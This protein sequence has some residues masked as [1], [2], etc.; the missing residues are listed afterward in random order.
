MLRH[1]S[2]RAM[3]LLL[4]MLV[5]GSGCAKTEDAA[6]NAADERGIVDHQHLDHRA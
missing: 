3:A 1:E 5:A 4:G 6:E 2:G